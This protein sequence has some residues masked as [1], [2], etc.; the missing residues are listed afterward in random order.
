MNLKYG[1]L[2]QMLN[3]LTSAYTHR[4]EQNIKYG[5]ALDTN[6]G[7]LFA[8]LAEGLELVRECAENVREWDN[9]DNAEGKVLDRYGADYGVQ[10][11]NASDALYRIFIQVKM[12]AQL[13]GGDWDTVIQS[14]GE[15]LG[16]EYSDI[17]SEDVFPA[18]IALYVDEDLLTDERRELIDQIAEAIKRIL[19]GGV[20]LRLYLRTYRTYTMRLPISHGT[21][22][23]VHGRPEF[24][25]GYRAS[26]VTRPTAHS[27]YFHVRLKPKRIG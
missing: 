13:S 3:M 23:S 2:K 16:V 25:S 21:F 19:T 8:L 15:L 27:A 9:I 4:D 17:D 20:G 6:I 18:K 26:K 5:R 10:R 14:A 1:Y 12:L 7:K 24:I 22:I 11:G